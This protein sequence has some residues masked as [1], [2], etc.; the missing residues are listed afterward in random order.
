MMKPIKGWGLAVGL[1]GLLM[2]MAANG[3]AAP[4]QWEQPAAALAE[5]IAEILGP[6]QARLTIRNASTISTY[7]IPVIRQL[8]DEDL[9]SRG[10]L[11]SGAESANIIRVTLSENIRERL[12]VA[13]IVEGNETRVAT[14]HVERETAITPV[15]PDQIVLRS[16]RIFTSQSNYPILAAIETNSGLMVLYP[17]R[18]ITYVLNSTGSRERDRF[19]ITERQVRNRDSRGLLLSS[20][21][22]HDFTA[23]IPG[24]QCTGTYP[25]PADPNAAYADGSMRCHDSDDPWPIADTG[26]PA[27][28]PKIKAFYN[29]ARNYFTGVV[30][31]SVGV[32]LPP[33]YTAV[34]LPRPDGAGLLIGGIDGKVQLAENATLKTVAGTRDWGSDFAVLHSG[35]GAG[36]QIIASGSGE[37]VTDSLRAYELP[38]LEAIPASA[39]LMMDGTVTALW[40]ERD[41]KSVFTIV[42]KAAGQG[43]QDSYE[44]DR[45]SANCN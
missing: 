15:P 22:G 35:C 16:Q 17:E 43:Q 14:V 37:A 36:T 44:V 41:G 23:F 4:S 45:V 11:A 38:A 27:G 9:K 40:S 5:Q 30:T 12:W 42:R 34:L 33:F 21:S 1:A 39:P 25:P 32:D 31:P 20:D 26:S 7:E 3:A 28:E 19:T 29:A 8:L 24:V 2:G 10:V 6:G 18:I 13:E